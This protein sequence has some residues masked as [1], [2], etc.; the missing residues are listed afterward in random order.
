MRKRLQ[1]AVKLV[2]VLSLLLALQ[3]DINAQFS[4]KVL[5]LGNSYT[6]VN[7]LPQM[8]Y[9]AALSAGDTLV[10]DSNTPGGERFMGHVSNG[11]S[12]N[13]IYT[14][15]WDYVVLQAQ[16]QEPSW[17]WS[18][19]QAEV[20]P[21]AETLCD[22]IRANYECSEPMFYVTW[23]RKNG[24]AQ[25]CQFVS[26]VCTYE[27]MDSALTAT[28][29]YMAN[30]NEAEMSPVGPVWRYIRNNYPALELY[31]G[32]ES[33]PSL[34]GSYAAACCFYT[35]I[36]KKDPTF[37]T[38]NSTLSANDANI[39]KAA[40]KTVVYD[41]LPLWDYTVNLAASSFTAVVNNQEVAFESLASDVDSLVWDF[42][43][44]NNSA[45]EDPLHQYDT[46][47]T[48]AVTLTTYKCGE[49][50]ESTQQVIIDPIMGIA[51]SNTLNAAITVYPN[52][53]R[54]FLTVD[55]K[56]QYKHATL[57]IYNLLGNKLSQQELQHTAK[58][59][60]DISTLQAGSYFIKVLLD[61]G[62]ESNIRFT[63]LDR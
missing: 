15:D 50:D 20:F 25:N 17:G 7:N 13:K 53:A 23:G 57:E 32:D 24:D 10:F 12:I 26:W 52:P 41:N 28:Y 19:M 33:H 16:S 58:V 37:I 43:D 5:F 29:T 55:I 38:W 42:G 34:L 49:S 62:N 61:N 44:G 22:T 2:I 48:F 4:K 21:Y 8:V 46:S 6:G 14:N 45:Q 11:S 3:Y 35:A 39:V 60:V 27:G 18:Q 36:F 54:T 1:L 30:E 63:K 40:A 47:G 59:N 51:T 31:S 9:D 56:L